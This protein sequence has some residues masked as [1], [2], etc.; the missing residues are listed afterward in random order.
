[1]SQESS[2]EPR[3][4]QKRKVVAAVDLGRLPIVGLLSA[5][6]AGPFNT[7]GNGGASLLTGWNPLGGGSTKA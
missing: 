5:G 2:E 4:I 1:M 3:V 6:V 7:Y